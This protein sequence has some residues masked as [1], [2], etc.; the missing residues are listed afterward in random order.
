[1]TLGNVWVC[2][3]AGRHY[4]FHLTMN[5]LNHV[6][7]LGHGEYESQL[8]RVG[9]GK[10]AQLVKCSPCKQEGLTSTPTR[11]VVYACDLSAG[12]DGVQENP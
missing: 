5:T 3:L 6:F 11:C 8:T 2:R 12:V 4:L 10:M 9:G 1:M 7:Q